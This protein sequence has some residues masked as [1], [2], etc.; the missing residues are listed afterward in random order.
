MRRRVLGRDEQGPTFGAAAPIDYAVNRVSR[1]RVAG[2]A[3]GGGKYTGYT[4]AAPSS[5]IAATGNLADTDLGANTSTAVLIV[6]A[7]EAG[8]S[9]HVLTVAPVTQ[10]TF[11]AF[12]LGMSG[13]ATPIPVYM[14]NGF[15]LGC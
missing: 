10:K 8:Q 12:Y 2:N 11:I 1:I 5:A 14:I 7:A 4:V 3:S 13:D 15:D 6:N 9:T